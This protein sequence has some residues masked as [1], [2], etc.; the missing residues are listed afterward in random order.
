MKSGWENLLAA[1]P[2]ILTFIAGIGISTVGILFLYLEM[3][4]RW[5]SKCRGI[6]TRSETE[7][8]E[9]YNHGLKCAMFVPAIEYE[10]VLNGRIH[11]TKVRSFSNWSLGDRLSALEVL[12]KYKL[13]AQVTVFFD[14]RNPERAA[15]EYGIGPGSV[16]CICLGA[17]MVFLAICDG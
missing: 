2:A 12:S 15:L 10:Y 3:R 9:F 4:P 17:F 1:Y 5:W 6:I 8:S 14:P 11:R 16:F 13:G 7:R